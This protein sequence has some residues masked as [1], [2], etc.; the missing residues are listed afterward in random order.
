MPT[1]SKRVPGPTET[2]PPFL[3]QK[4]NEK[5]E[6]I[7][8]NSDGNR[9]DGR[10]PAEMRPIFLKAGVISQA[11]G[12]AYI[13]QH[14]TKVICAVYGPHEYQRREGFSMKGKLRCEVKFATFSCRQRGSHQTDTR[15]KEAALVIQ[16]AL[17]PAV[18]LH[19]FPK[20][21]LDIF[22]TVLQNDGSALGAALTCASA[23]VADAGIEMYDLVIGCQMRQAGETMLLDPTV[24]EEYHSRLVKNAESNHGAV[25]VA[26]LPSIDQVSALVQKGNLES[27]IALQ[28]L[29]TCTEACQRIYPVVQQCLTKAVQSREKTM[30]TSETKT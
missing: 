4:K 6:T 2:Q 30:D 26:L 12:S 18:C 22:V 8:V 5:A 9:H 7:L 1:D 21:Q 29:K 10:K 23:A 11:R 19:K 16:Q 25:T 15:E 14:N 13:E 3:Y 24:Q 20:S 28:V 27:D 17:E